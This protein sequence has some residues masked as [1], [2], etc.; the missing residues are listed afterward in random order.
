LPKNKLPIGLL[1]ELRE[2]LDDSQIL[3]SVDLVDL[4]ES[5]ADFKEKVLK[6]SIVWK[7]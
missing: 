5:S 1:S 7:D 2:S 3:Y 4:S 6:D